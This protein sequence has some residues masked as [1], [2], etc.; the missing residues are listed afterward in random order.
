MADVINITTMKILESV[1]TPDYTKPGEIHYDNG[2]WKELHKI[3]PL[4]S[5]ESKYWTWDGKDV[6]EMSDEEKSVVDYIPP[7]PEPTAEQIAQQAE[8]VRR[9]S[10]KTD[11]EKIYPFRSDELQEIRMILAEEFPN[12]ER[13]QLY[14]SNIEYILSKYP[15]E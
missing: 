9:N 4:P 10:I 15:K 8:D 11:I 13:A 14:N 12:N 1:N 6:V 3:R 7:P 5:C 2:N